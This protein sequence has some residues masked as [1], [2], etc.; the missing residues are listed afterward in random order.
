MQIFL[1][2]LAAATALHVI[3]FFTTVAVGYVKT[4]TYRPNMADAWENVEVLQQEVAFGSTVSPFSTIGTFM[5]LTLLCALVL[6]TYQ[7]LAG[8]VNL[9]S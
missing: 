9:K 5:V 4:I 8:N 3:Y 7:K 6:Y 2:S 1:K